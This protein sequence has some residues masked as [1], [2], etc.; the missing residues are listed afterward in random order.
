MNWFFDET[1]D[2]EW[3]A[4]VDN[5]TLMPFGWLEELVRVASENEID[6]IQAK[7]YFINSHYG[8]WKYFEDNNKTINLNNGCLI[9]YQCVGGSGIAIRAGAIK[10][11]IEP[12]ELIWGW[13]FFQM[14]NK[15]GSR[16][17][18]G[19]HKNSKTA[20]GMLIRN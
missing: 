19:W 9:P 18:P 6:I 2:S 10:D 8:D 1:K 20:I 17:R 5:D 15:P 3:V 11:H 13:S 16:I 12:E 7:H 4:K 14:D